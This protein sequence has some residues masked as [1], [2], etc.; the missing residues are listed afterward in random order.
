MTVQF[1]FLSGGTQRVAFLWMEAQGPLF[2]PYGEG[3]KIFLQPFLVHFVFNDV[4]A[5]GVISKQTDL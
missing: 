3:I 2:L 4:T 1:S 5:Q